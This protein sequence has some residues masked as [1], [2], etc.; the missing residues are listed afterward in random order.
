MSRRPS[1][2]S[3]AALIVLTTA[4]AIATI[5]PPSGA[6][7]PTVG[8]WTKLPPPSVRDAATALDRPRNRLLIFGGNTNDLPNNELWALSLG[9]SP[10]WIQ[11]ATYGT[12]P[13]ARH[14]HNMI[15]DPA[16]D[17]LWVFGGAD[18][19]NA[20]LNDVWTL[21]LS[22]VLPTWTHLSP[23]GTPPVARAY[24]SAMLDTTNDRVLIFG[25][26]QVQNSNGPPSGLLSDVWAMSLTGPPAWTQLS[27]TGS[28]PSARAGVQMIWDGTNQRLVLYGG[29]DGNMLG[30]TYA[31]DLS[32]APAWSTLSPTG[33]PPDNRA[34]GSAVWDPMGAQMLVYGG[35]GGNGNL[36][37][38]DLWSLSLGGSPA[39]THLT[40]AGGP[41]SARQSPQ[42][43][44]DPMTQ[45]MVMYGGGGDGNGG[46]T[47]DLTWKLG[48]GGSLSWAQ[49]G[50]GGMPQ[51]EGATAI[52]DPVGHRLV[53][54]GGRP[55][56]SYSNDVW[57][58][59]LIGN[60]TQLTPTGTPPTPRT[61]QTTIYDPVRNRMLVYGGTDS[62]NTYGDVWALS[63]SVSP[64]WT[65][66]VTTGGP[67]SARFQHVAVYD[68]LRD[69]MVI[70]GGG[71]PGDTGAIWA[72]SLGTNTW[73]SV[74]PSISGPGFRQGHV[75]VYDPLNDRLVLFGG[76]S[77][78]VVWAVNF[79][80]SPAWSQLTCDGT[81]P[82]SRYGMAVSYDAPA[83]GM[84]VFG[85][86]VATRDTTSNATTFLHL[87][88]GTPAWTMLDL[89]ATL[90]AERQD[91]M[92]AMDQGNESFYIAGGCCS[93]STDTWVTT[94]DH[95]T[96]TLAS[97]VST[98]ATPR[99]VDVKWW[100]SDPNTSV[101]IERNG[102]SGWS[103]FQIRLPDGSGILELSDTDVTPGQRY[104]YRL[105]SSGEAPM[106]EVWIDVPAMA[107][108]LALGGFRP[109]PAPAGA[110][111]FFT[112]SGASPAHLEVLD[113]AGRHVLS[114]EV[115]NLGSGTHMVR[116]DGATPGFYLMRLTQSGHTVTAK[117][118]LTR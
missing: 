96:A 73:S 71:G 110:A 91:A 23:S 105:R 77:D 81:A 44:Y 27:P 31:L 89:G 36:N 60:W 35:Y 103:V 46:T 84:M 20:T 70:H 7:T 72:L 53:T 58:Y 39:W 76:S 118:T 17:L 98:T 55:Y 34:V 8:S 38:S 85:G 59:D 9:G 90:P 75:G 104:G 117:A 43:V 14:N 15:V 16:H 99:Q 56:P 102:G 69:R 114:R 95:V 51:R 82:R 97:M 45:S 67:P 66:V 94:I 111:V 2:T 1:A 18:V 6:G 12:P 33:G 62:V 30:D 37:L 49:I 28:G 50:A 54:F 88:T 13:P 100:V 74:L 87:G 115:G 106:G 25:G 116:V 24:A 57:T 4:L 109:N 29:F 61:G 40:P 41:P 92:A 21:S 47:H 107:S 63:L 79:S 108:G 80:G 112:L 78:D 83:H 93:N 52:F 113:V 3:R 68:A 101:S 19:N 48:L 11:I 64:A 26:A 32:G 5:A 86:T 10:A 42:S 65:Q 22:S